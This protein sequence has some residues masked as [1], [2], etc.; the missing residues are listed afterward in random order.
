[1]VIIGDRNYPLMDNFN[2]KLAKTDNSTLV[3]SSRDTIRAG[4]HPYKDG[5]P[6]F[7][8]ECARK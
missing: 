1:M 5:R 2:I 7:A 4:N 8:E 6:F 3:L